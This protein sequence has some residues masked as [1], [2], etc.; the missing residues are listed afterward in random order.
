M[1]VPDVLRDLLEAVGPSGHEEQAARV[2]REAAAGFAEVDSDTLGTSYARVRA[3]E[4]APTLALVGH[5]DE[6]GIAITTIGDD[7]LLSFT[8]IGGFRPETLAGQ[9]VRLLGPRGDVRGVVGGR[10]PAGSEPKGEP[11][12]LEH[13]DLYVDIGARGREDAEGLVRIGDAGVWEGAPFEL[14]NGRVVSRALDN[15]LG[16]YVAL[17]AARRI[18]EAG[19]ASADVVAVAAVSEEVGHFGAGPAAFA[20]EPRVA[21]AIDVTGATDQPGGNPRR[22]GKIELGG[23]PVITRGP[24]INAHVYRLLLDA[25][26]REEIPHA[27]KVAT[28]ATR[29]DADELHVSRSG[30]PTGLVS[31]PIR[32]LHT[33][34]ELVSLDDLEGAIRLVVSFARSLTRE[35]SFVR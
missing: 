3:G 12:P 35:Q 28:T 17:E 34:C 33:P 14:R 13:S 18:A 29:T 25:A 1:A 27:I 21:L 30:V 15:R 23:G 20:L 16:S 7:G 5:I 6:I 31:I 22:F 26:E 11:A 4:G 19:D 2:W 32:Y 8:T 24:M 10:G 9:R